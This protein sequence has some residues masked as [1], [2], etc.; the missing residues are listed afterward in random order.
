MKIS[1]PDFLMV[2]FSQIFQRPLRWAGDLET[3]LLQGQLT[4]VPIDRPVFICGLARSGST[5]LLELLAALPGVATHRYCDFPFLTIP[6]LW[7]RYLGKFER[8]EQPIERPHKDRIQITR[9]SPEAMEEPLWNAWFPQ[10]H[11]PA[12]NTHR[13]TAELRGEAFEQFHRAH[14]QKVLLLRDGQRYVAKN[15]YHATRIEYLASLYPNAEF[16]VPV[17]HPLAHVESLVRQHRLFCDYASREPRVPAYLAA[18]GHFEF[19]PQRLPIYVDRSAGER[20][21]ER[22]QAGDE[23][24]GYSIQWNEV[25]GLVRDLQSHSPLAGRIHVVRYEDFCAS[26]QRVF[27][28]LLDAVGL[29]KVP[30]SHAPS[31]QSIS[32]SQ[33]A[34][35]L[36]VSQQ[37]AVWAHLGEVAEHFGYRREEPF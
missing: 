36:D 15:N 7:N 27:A 12:A 23:H 4:N 11:S 29:G 24:G 28:D 16:I 10:L 37:R 18:A 34:T 8:A 21:I 32:Q 2:R 30:E 17:R 9:R 35:T 13:M 22:W 1:T 5:V 20:I 33:H 14:L 31:L 6:Y 3:S 25:Y 26:P 19:G